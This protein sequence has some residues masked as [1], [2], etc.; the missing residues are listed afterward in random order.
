MPTTALVTDMNQPLASAAGNAVEVRNAADFLTGKSRDSRLLDV[1]LSLAAEM[2]VSGG[3]A[4][5]VEDAKIRALAALVDGSAAE[6]FNR[7]VAELGGPLDFLADPDSHLETAPIVSACLAERE[8][9]VTGYDTRKVGLS[10]VQLG[11]GRTRP[12]DPVD[13]AVGLTRLLPIGTRVE[14]GTPLAFIHA[15][16]DDQLSIAG[17]QLRAAVHL[18]DE[19]PGDSAVIIGRYG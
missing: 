9:F 14:K 13:P 10:V 12:G 19:P 6:C 2:L 3:L 15:R 5:N 16:N 1:T 8:G 7:M 18:G 17:K 4:T 11:G